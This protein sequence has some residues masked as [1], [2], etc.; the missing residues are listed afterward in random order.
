MIRAVESQVRIWI[1]DAD[2]RVT[3]LARE[4]RDLGFAV[5]GD[6]GNIGSRTETEAARWCDVV[7]L[8]TSSES[9]DPELALLAGLAL[10]AQ[11]PLVFVGPVPVRA[12]ALAALAHTLIEPLSTEAIAFQIQALGAKTADRRARRGELAAQKVETGPPRYAADATDP[13]I[14]K[15]AQA[16]QIE[17]SEF[18][19]TMLRALAR[20]RGIASLG[21]DSWATKHVTGGRASVVDALAWVDG[22]APFNPIPVE[23]KARASRA[24]VEQVF[25]ILAASGATIG[26]LVVGEARGL[27]DPQVDERDGRFLITISADSLSRESALFSRWVRAIRNDLAHGRRVRGEI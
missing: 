10:G 20:D 16:R 2:G 3:G 14:E 25:S 26:V 15:V 5:E 23:F 22:A 1:A 24:A 19:S 11:R 7:L 13:T 8:A 6:Q 4:L 17:S 21:G 27:D 9:L 12:P 18:E